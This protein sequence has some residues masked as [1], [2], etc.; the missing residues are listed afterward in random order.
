MRTWSWL[1]VVATALVLLS[2]TVVTAAEW[3][4]IS[5]KDG[6]LVER[7]SIAGSAFAE[8][9]ATA[10]S[11]LSPSAVFETVWGHRDYM[12]FIPHLTRLDILSDTGDERVIYEQ[13]KLP[14]ASDRDYTVRLRKRVDTVA[15]RYEIDFASANDV[16]PPPDSGHQRVRSIRGSWMIEPGPDGAGSTVRYEIVTDPGGSLF[17]WIVNRAQRTAVPDLVRAVLKRA[18]EKTG[19]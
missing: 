13:V 17:V 9:R 2:S 6:V 12:Q 10:Q 4:K 3:E 11:L 5:D 18:R 8:I 7:R 1:W 19:W 16:G 14:L 15:Q